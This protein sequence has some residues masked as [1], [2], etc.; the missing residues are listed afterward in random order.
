[1]SGNGFAPLAALFDVLAAHWPAV[2]E[3]WRAEVVKLYTG[4]A[5]SIGT[6]AAVN[7]GVYRDNLRHGETSGYLSRLRAH[8]EALARLQVPFHVIM[9]SLHHYEEKC[10][11]VLRVHLE[12]N[13]ALWT[14]VS[15]LD[16]IVHAGIASLAEG[17]FTA[18]RS[19][20]S[21]DMLAHV[22][23]TTATLCHRVNNPLAS[24][25]GGLEVLLRRQDLE[26]G[27]RDKL[28]RLE[29]AARRIE[30]ALRELAESN[31]FTK[32]PYLSEVKILSPTAPPAS[33]PAPATRHT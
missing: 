11:D 27:L 1:M 2:E 4:P 6:L 22:H 5:E 28:Q 13:P 9:L 10:G 30:V 12:A 8:G 15:G 33:G 24:I 7:V 21:R 3:E 19:D 17:Y 20:Q 14:G 32:T 18:L 26:P 29:T 16:R 23:D 31:S 25:L